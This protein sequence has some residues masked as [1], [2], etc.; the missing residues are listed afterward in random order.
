MYIPKSKQ[1]KSPKIA[2]KL[3]D[4][5]TGFR[6][7]G[8]YVQ[9]YKGNFYK[10]SNITSKS[11]KL[12]Y[13]PDSLTTSNTLGL[14]TVTPTPSSKDYAKGGLVRY[15]VKDGR[16]GRVVETSRQQYLEQQLEGK[17]YRRTLKV[18]WYITGPLEDSVMNG[19]VYP[20]TRSKNLDVVKQAEK[21]LPGIGE[22]VLNNPAQFVK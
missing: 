5:E 1:I 10:G 17:L 6:Y 20:G 11:V 18:F 14:Y 22:Q 4:I 13:V 8:K 21:E 12:K 15:F 19:Y 2:G 16:S 3:Y 7:T 9:D